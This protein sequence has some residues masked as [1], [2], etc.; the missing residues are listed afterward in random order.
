MWT[1]RVVVLSINLS[2]P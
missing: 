2:E 1:L